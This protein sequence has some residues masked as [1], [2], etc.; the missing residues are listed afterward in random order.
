[1]HEWVIV[2]TMSEGAHVIGYVWAE[3]EGVAI[4]IA[5]NRVDLV[6]QEG[7]LESASCDDT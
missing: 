1:M 5:V 4:L 6:G 7:S 2:R 3:D